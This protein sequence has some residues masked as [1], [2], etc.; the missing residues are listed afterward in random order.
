MVSIPTWL[1]VNEA[2]P[3]TSKDD[4]LAVIQRTHFFSPPSFGYEWIAGKERGIVSACQ[5][6][7]IDKQQD[8]R[9]LPDNPPSRQLLPRCRAANLLLISERLGC[10]WLH[11]NGEVKKG[12][13]CCVINLS[14]C[15]YSTSFI[16]T[17]DSLLSANCTNQAL[18]W[19]TER[20]Y[21]ASVWAVA[22][23]ERLMRQRTVS[24]NED[25][26]L[27]WKSSRETRKTPHSYNHHHLHV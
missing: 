21:K 27:R 2:Q 16:A 1:A 9:S 10:D 14:T 25:S 3:D 24:H 6:T 22:T 17:T 12:L 19:E 8:T 5:P 11:M 7:Q 20:E 18:I 15:T 4:G 23:V 13:K 26:L